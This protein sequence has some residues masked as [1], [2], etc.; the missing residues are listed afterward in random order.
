MCVLSKIDS[1]E[2]DLS[3]S[4]IF[5]LKLR[6]IKVVRK[7][8]NQIDRNVPSTN[9]YYTLLVSPYFHNQFSSESTPT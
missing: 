9:R 8:Y 6:I 4:N 5:F 1:Y 7:K 3:N 2:P